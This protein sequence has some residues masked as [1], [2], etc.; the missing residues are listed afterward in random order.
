MKFN[1]KEAASNF[2]K[3]TRLPRT[4]TVLGLRKPI[5]VKIG[6]QELLVVR[7]TRKNFLKAAS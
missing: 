2:M 7:L 6:G 1:G 3:A 5:A 4:Q